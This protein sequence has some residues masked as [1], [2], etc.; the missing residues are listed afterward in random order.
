MYARVG[1]SSV[2]KS[3][4]ICGPFFTTTKQIRQG[5]GNRLLQRGLARRVDGKR[6]DIET[7]P[8]VCGGLEQRELHKIDVEQLCQSDT[9]LLYIYRQV[10]GL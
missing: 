4:I 2:P 5:R 6:I 9:P 8:I 7:I 3:K 1:S 10:N